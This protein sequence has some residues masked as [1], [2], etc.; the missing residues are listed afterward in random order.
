MSDKKI[1]ERVRSIVASADLETLT[2]RKLREQL[3][4][5]LGIDLSQRKF[6][7]LG[8]MPKAWRFCPD[9]RTD[10][11]RRPTACSS[12]APWRFEEAQK[13]IYEQKLGMKQ[14]SEG[15]LT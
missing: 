13:R 14:Q 12:Y 5:E 1:Q 7:M 9:S 11:Y 4:A 15:D 6:E 3:E 10:D 8:M 2:G